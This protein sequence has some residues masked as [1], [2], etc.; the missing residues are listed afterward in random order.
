MRVDRGA[1]FSWGPELTVSVQRLP[2]HDLT[3]ILKGVAAALKERG[4]HVV[5]SQIAH[6]VVLDACAY[7]AAQQG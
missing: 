4:W 1:L 5:T 6:P 3:P 7:L 2:G